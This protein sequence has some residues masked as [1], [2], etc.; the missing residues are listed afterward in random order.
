MFIDEFYSKLGFL[1]RNKQKF[2]ND[3]Y[4][5]VSFCIESLKN[6]NFSIDEF[7]VPKTNKSIGKIKNIERTNGRYVHLEKTTSKYKAIKRDEYKLSK[8]ID[9]A[10]SKDLYFATFVYIVGNIEDYFSKVVELILNYDNNRLMCTVNGIN[11]TNNYSVIDIINSLDKQEMI[12]RIVQDRII[13]IFYAKPSCYKEY[14]VKA[15]GIDIDEHYWYTWFE[16][17]ATRDLIVHNNGV[18]NSIYIEKSSAQARGNIGDIILIDSKYYEESI[19]F[20]KSL[21]GQIDKQIRNCFLKDYKV[22]K[23]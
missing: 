14:F 13:S 1:R 2:L 4:I 21:V 15:L 20:L 8:L 6:R 23:T 9:S 22:N 10:T 7:I 11:F 17:K 3:T 18:I 16:I 19:S 5:W 12:K